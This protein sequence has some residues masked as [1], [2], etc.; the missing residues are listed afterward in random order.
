MCDFSSKFI[1]VAV[2]LVL[3][4]NINIGPNDDPLSLLILVTGS[5]VVWLPPQV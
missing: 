5:L 4:A 2:T 1:F 3:V